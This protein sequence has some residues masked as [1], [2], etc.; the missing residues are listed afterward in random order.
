VN[1]GVSFTTEMQ[2]DGA[3]LRFR[4]SFETLSPRRTKL[5]QRI[6]LSGDN[7]PAYAAQVEAGFGATL[8]DGMRRIAAEMESA[9]REANR[10]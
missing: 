2:L 5:T 3:T 8:A 10:V 4:W 1:P 7:A 6:T 9:E